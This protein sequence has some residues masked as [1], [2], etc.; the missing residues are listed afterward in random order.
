MNAR[1]RRG[2]G[3][4]LVALASA[5]ALV[6]SVLAVSGSDPAEAG[7][8]AT[9]GD[10]VEITSLPAG[11]QECGT[12]PGAN[13]TAN[14]LSS[15]RAVHEIYA[16]AEKQNYV[17]PANLTVDFGPQSPSWMFGT[18][19]S[20]EAQILGESYPLLAGDTVSSFLLHTDLPYTDPAAT[21]SQSSGIL[22]LDPPGFQPYGM[23]FTDA[24]L[25]ATDSLGAP[26]VLYPTVDTNRGWEF[27]CVGTS[28]FTGIACS[29]AY[30]AFVDSFQIGP[31]GELNVLEDITNGMD[32]TRVLENI[33]D[34][35]TVSCPGPLAVTVGADAEASGTFAD[36]D[37]FPI[38]TLSANR[39]AVTQVGTG[40]SGS[41]SWDLDTSVSIESGPIVITATDEQGR[42]GSCTFTLTVNQVVAQVVQ[43]GGK[44]NIGGTKPTAASPTV[45]TV[46]L[47]KKV[48]GSKV[49][50]SSLSSSA[51]AA[52][53]LAQRPQDEAAPRPTSV[54]S[55][56][57]Q[58][59]GNV[60]GPSSL[61]SLARLESG[62][63]PDC[64]V[65]AVNVCFGQLI[66]IDPGVG[67]VSKAKPVK[68][69]MEWLK[70]PR[71]DSRLSTLWVTKL[72]AGTN[73]RVTKRVP[74]CVKALKEYVNTP[75]LAK[76]SFPKGNYRTDVLLLSGDPK[77]SRR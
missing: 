34:P 1:G 45:A 59:A 13:N 62:G 75:C 8:A 27:D 53:A 67:H 28:V 36:N 9:S 54:P 37:S 10:I 31:T 68:L 32:Q 61:V 60:T 14:C 76:A 33:P 22:Y 41:W 38:V 16:F 64:T 25:G 43:P 57:V 55:G 24:R 19:Y 47:P 6:A 48:P 39:G 70:D 73:T 65:A 72:K 3:R 51:A 5:V 71:K 11:V 77:F 56:S 17:L 29:P 58:A 23:I 49:R 21:P 44:L 15:P 74:A 12:T 40:R 2:V 52:T 4:V 18:T 35:P 50:A 30:N 26:G 7:I 42:T 66:S 20:T 46:K 63:D 69:R